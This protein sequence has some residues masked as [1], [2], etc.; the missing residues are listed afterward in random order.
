MFSFFRK[1][2][3]LEAMIL[4]LYNDA[5]NN[6]KDNAQADFKQLETAFTAFRDSGRLSAKQQEHYGRILDEYR[7]MLQDFTH[8]DQ[9][10][11]DVGT[12]KGGT[13]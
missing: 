13:L 5:S 9:G 2:K 6:Y 10:R 12:W 7:V 4:K 3:E 8:A 11:K 1:N